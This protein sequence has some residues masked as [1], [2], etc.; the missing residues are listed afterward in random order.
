MLEEIFGY[1]A[2][3]LL[4]ISILPQIYHTYKT[5]KVEDLS[6]IFLC[7]QLITCT[8]W[9]IYGILLK[10]IPLIGANLCVL[11]Q[12]IILTFFKKIYSNT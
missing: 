8:L 12:L 10:E 5:K 3:C 7:L 1:S 2:A 11:T 4:V 6:Y 9:I